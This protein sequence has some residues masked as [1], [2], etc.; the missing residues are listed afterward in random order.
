MQRV[1]GRQNS[2]MDSL[3]LPGFSIRIAVIFISTTTADPAVVAC[4]GRG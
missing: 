2:G 4:L 1:S 3:D